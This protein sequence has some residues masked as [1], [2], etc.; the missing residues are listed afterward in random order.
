MNKFLLLIFGVL[1]IIVLAFSYKNW[2]S[3]GIAAEHNGRK[4]IAKIEQ[5][6]VEHKAAEIKK[7]IPDK[8]KKSPI[9]DFLRYRA[10]S[11]NK[12]NLSIIGSNLVIESSTNF[13]FK[14][15]ESQ[16]K[17]KLKSEYD[18]LDNLEVKHYGFKSYSTSDFI[19]SKKIDVVVKDNPDV[20]FI[21]NFIINNYR[22]SISIDQTNSDIKEIISQLQNKLPK[23]KIIIMSPN[24]ILNDQNQNN[25][26]LNYKDYINNTSK[27]SMNNGLLYLDF[28]LEIEKYLESKNLLIVDVI[29]NDFVRPNDTGNL[30]IG[31]ILYEYLKN[32]LVSFD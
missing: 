20:I 3:K 15:W 23:T 17:S 5:K 13:T 2:V 27:F 30:L 18:E 14:G 8:N 31:D 21:E 10:L 26:G 6:E 4:I 24:P 32:S 7:L 12:V 19:K 1:C 16:L 9:V 22:Q 29:E 28:Y 11:N 25:L